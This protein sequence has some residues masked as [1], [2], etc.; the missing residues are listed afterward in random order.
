MKWIGCV[1]AGALLLFVSGE[2]L[3]ETCSEIDADAKR[4]LASAAQRSDF[5]ALQHLAKRA[6][7]NP[8]CDGEYVFRLARDL[9]L[10]ALHDLEQKAKAENRALT[11]RELQPL[12]EI[13][14]PWQLMVHLGDANFAERHWLKAFD[15]YAIALANLN[16]GKDDERQVFGEVY[17]NAIVA[18]AYLENESANDR[19]DSRPTAPQFR[20]FRGGPPVE[21]TFLEEVVWNRV[22][23]SGD[24]LLLQA[25]LVE[26]P[27]G[28]HAAMAKTRLA[29]LAK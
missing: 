4:L 2:A 7:E 12:A 22:G 10:V 11:S 1:F 18:R 16:A 24:R 21:R 14:K 27:D 26:F 15:S 23:P 20:T 6:S 29:E 8:G 28:A 9:V 13:S 19:S 17:A 3:A 5:T 25:Y